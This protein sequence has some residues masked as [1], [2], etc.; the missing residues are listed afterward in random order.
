[1]EDDF[2]KAP[3]SISELRSGRTDRAKD[4]TVRDALVNMLRQIDSGDRTYDMVVIAYARRLEDDHLKVGCF[5]AGTKN[6]L[7]A[8]GI[9]AVAAHCI[10]IEGP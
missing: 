6:N 8:A 9:A 3:V 2:S 5:I 10:N 1:M 7:E 4:W